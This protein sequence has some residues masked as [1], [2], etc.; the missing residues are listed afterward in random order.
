MPP[1]PLDPQTDWSPLGRG[2]VT[3]AGAPS[4]ARLARWAARGVTDVLT[5]QRADEMRPWLPAACAELGMTWR[6]LPISGRRMERAEDR[7]SLAAL[8]GLAAEMGQDPPRLLVAHCAAGLHR[9]GVALYVMLR[10]AGN[11]SDAALALVRRARPLT[12]EELIRATRRSGVL[13]ER[14]EAIFQRLQAG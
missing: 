10:C 7:A 13:M 5:L 12:G 14:A 2:H 9:T 6:H 3:A 4:R 11:D 1:D 8:P